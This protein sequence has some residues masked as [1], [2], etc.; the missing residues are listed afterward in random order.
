M[1]TSLIRRFRLGIAALLVAALNWG[2]CSHAVAQTAPPLSTFFANDDI[3]D[4]KLSSSGRFIALTVANK[5]GRTV[6]A[7]V[8]LASDAPP[9]VVAATPDAD[10]RSFE[11]VNDDRL[12]YN[13]VDLLS[14]GSDQTFG[15][16]LFSVRRDGSEARQLIRIGPISQYSKITANALAGDHGLIFVPRDGGNDVIVG[17]YQYDIERNFVAVLPKRLDVTTGRARAAASGYPSGA[18]AWVFDRAG[19]PR[20]VWTGV[21]DTSEVFWR[22]AGKSTWRSLVKAPRLELPW[23]PIAIDS[24]DRLYVAAKTAGSTSVLKRFDFASGAPEPV[25]I[26]SAPGFDLFGG[27]IFDNEIDRRL[28]G[29]RVDTDAETT[30]WYDPLSKKLQALADARFPGRV[31]RISCRECGSAGAMLVR[32][33]SDQEPG[34]FSVY[35]PATDKWTT[36]G[37]ARRTL[38]PQQM[39]QLDFHR[40]KARDGLDLP[41]WITT[42]RGKPAAPRAAVVLVHGGPWVRGTSWRWSADAQF[43]ASRG[44]V[45]I[46][47]EY[48]G[49]SG[50]G[51]SHLRAGFKNWGTTMQDDVADAVRWAAAKGL[52]DPGR[53][54]IAGASY[55]GYAT[56]MGA[57]RHPDL[58]RCGVAWVA[59]SDPRLLYSAS[60]VSDISRV[61]VE[62]FYPNMIGDLV[63]DEAMLKAASPL[64]R[65]GEIRIPMLMA[66]GAQDSRVPLEHGTRMRAALRAAGNEPEYVVYTGEGH[67]WLKVENRIDFWQRVE[68]FLAKHLN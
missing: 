26:A 46:E 51:E 61:G 50:F 62:Y 10:I 7:V 59:V 25:P 8:E 9:T 68:K 11:W 5:S 1:T 52:V 65:A 40:I 47:P 3:S 14:A 38:D 29:V 20:A 13:I 32:S 31:N 41:V 43:L 53:V 33:F 67:G 44:Y 4:V 12:V 58:Y 17:Q 15:P 18:L 57:I 42:P 6:L 23:Y 19:E 2:V 36:I 45:V 55:G 16:G 28:V 22:D 63:K 56:L 21:G 27:L 66:F 60:W 34:V 39:A 37:Q 64:E 49:S 30:F 35:R 54:C 48:R 24:A